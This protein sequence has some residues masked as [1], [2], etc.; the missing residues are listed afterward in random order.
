MLDAQAQQ[1]TPATHASPD[2]HTVV[3]AKLAPL[4][5]V[6]ARGEATR[7][8]I[9]RAAEE[10]F[11]VRGFHVA[12][13]SSVTTR[14]GVGQG[15]FYL[16]FRTKEEVF[17]TLVRDIGQ[18]LRDR[19]QAAIKAEPARTPQAAMKILVEFTCGDSG[20]YR[21]VQESQFVEAS[22]Y[23]DFHERLTQVLAG[24]LPS[25]AGLAQAPAT[26]LLAL[27]LLGVGQAVGLKHG[28]GDW[29]KSSAPVQ[30]QVGELVSRL[31]TPSA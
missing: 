1:A 31:I 9:L 27:A 5:P 2:D 12:S 29:R 11:S 7:Q 30:A 8:R 18:Q 16:Y 13:V 15:T 22:V 24:A 19:M 21:I 6:T 3:T 17:V 14:A 23:R 20:L 28:T 10:E 25:S 4:V 26:D